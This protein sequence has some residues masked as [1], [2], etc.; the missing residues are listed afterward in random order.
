MSYESDCRVSALLALQRTLNIGPD[1]AEE[2]LVALVAY[3]GCVFVRD[4]DD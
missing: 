2:L 1:Q 3:F 4:T